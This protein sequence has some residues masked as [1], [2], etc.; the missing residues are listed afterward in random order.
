MEISKNVYISIY[1]VFIIIIMEL[2]TFYGAT[3]TVHNRIKKKSINSSYVLKKNINESLDKPIKN[4]VL[5]DIEIP[6]ISKVVFNKPVE[7]V[8]EILSDRERRL[9][10]R[11]NRSLIAIGICIII[12]LL[13]LI[14][15]CMD[16]VKADPTELNKDMI[17][18]GS[19][20]IG[21][22]LLVQF[23]YVI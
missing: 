4:S 15:K 21:I 22:F 20:T 23:H 6:K 14:W 7:T 2:L 10:N 18:Y 8:L 3:F 13:Y 1:A 12:G 9:V 17:K 19:I 5:L 11:V 16:Y